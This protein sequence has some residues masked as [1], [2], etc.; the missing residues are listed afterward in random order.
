MMVYRHKGSE[1]PVAAEAGSRADRKMQA[2]KN[3]T[4]TNP[5]AR[6]KK[7]DLKPDTKKPEKSG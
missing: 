3:Y 1:Q 5:D 7:T 6:P 4:C 2:N